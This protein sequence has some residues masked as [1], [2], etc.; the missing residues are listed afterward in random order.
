MIFQSAICFIFGGFGMDTAAIIGSIIGA[1]IAGVFGIVAKYL[2]LKF[3]EKKNAAPDVLI[4]KPTEEADLAAEP[5]L[6]PE[7]AGDSKSERSRKTLSKISVIFFI[8]A[9]I[10]ALFIIAT[11]IT[12]S[13]NNKEAV[14]DIA[15]MANEAVTTTTTASPA[16][17]AA[18]YEDSIAVVVGLDGIVMGN[19]FA[20]ERG[21]E[22]YIISTFKTINQIFYQVEADG[23]GVF[24]FDFAKHNDILSSDLTLVGYSPLY[25]IAVLKT[26]GD[27]GIKGYSLSETAPLALSEITVI[28]TAMDDADKRGIVR[29]GELLSINYENPISHNTEYLTDVKAEGMRGSPVFA[30]DL[31]SVVGICAGSVSGD[32]NVIIPIS[33]L[34]TVFEEMDKPDSSITPF[35]VKE[36]AQKV[37]YHTT[38][39]NGMENV[40]NYNNKTVF[41]RIPGDYSKFYEYSSIEDGS[42]YETGLMGYAQEDGDG[43]L[44]RDN[45]NKLLYRTFSSGEESTAAEYGHFLEGGDTI[46]KTRTFLHYYLDGSQMRV[47]DPGNGQIIYLN[48]GKNFMYYYPDN[49]TSLACNNEYVQF[50]HTTDEDKYLFIFP[51]G[52]TDLTNFGDKLPD[53]LKIEVNEEG[54]TVEDT[55]NGVVARIKKSGVYSVKTSSLMGGYSSD[56]DYVLGR[57]T[58]TNEDEEDLN[59]YIYPKEDGTFEYYGWYT[60]YESTG[61]ELSYVQDNLRSFKLESANGIISV[62]DKFNGGRYIIYSNVTG[63]SAA[64]FHELI[65]YKISSGEKGMK[66]DP[67]NTVIGYYGSSELIGEP[68]PYVLDYHDLPDKE[69]SE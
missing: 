1:V 40:L 64:I 68:F 18:L 58:E 35:S 2:E 49:I 33:Y 6:L 26:S 11:A 44:I 10:I 25:N 9:G 16:D 56:G 3:E 69:D 14:D 37:K 21:G 53:N 28:G 8:V 42:V 43:W 22:T 61:F 7:T 23:G 24:T 60:A 51:D 47:V 34:K 4:K 29:K 17:T 38:V 32:D 63:D 27:P 5:V 62:T 45:D 13:I 54:L 57:Y 20:L 65:G 59:V 50:Q 66:I 55:A 48:N 39:I 41:T 31:T 12:A 67:Y 36:F 52:S 19:A 15:A 30:D 46:D